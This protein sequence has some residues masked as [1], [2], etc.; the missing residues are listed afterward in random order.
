MAE[1][2]NLFDPC[3]KIGKE[4]FNL[5]EEDARS[6][7]EQMR[8]HAKTIT[9][10]DVQV[11]IKKIMKEQSAMHKKWARQKR[12]SAR[13]NLLK[14]NR[15]WRR[16]QNTHAEREKLRRDHPLFF[17]RILKLF[18]KDSKE[19]LDISDEIIALYDGST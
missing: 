16:I 19:E 14:G 11:R 8:K 13:N 3:L 10:G 18:G 7:V 2:S 17:A 5:T 4:I 12:F 1:Q 15:E 9:E 6:I